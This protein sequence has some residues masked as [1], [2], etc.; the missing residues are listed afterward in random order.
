MCIMSPDLKSYWGEAHRVAQKLE[1]LVRVSRITA[2]EVE[3]RLGLGSGVLHRVF[4]GRINL[5]M[6]LIL[7]VLDV[8][9]VEPAEF[10]Q[11]AFEEPGAENSSASLLRLLRETRVTKEPPVAPALPSAPVPS[12]EELYQRIEEVLRRRGLIDEDQPVDAPLGN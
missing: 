3:R 2:R 4:A 10:F 1:S 5:K 11:L 6:S 8:L 12:E 7:A 9:A